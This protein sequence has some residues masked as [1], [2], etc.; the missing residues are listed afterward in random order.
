MPSFGTDL[1]IYNNDGTATLG[2]ILLVDKTDKGSIAYVNDSGISPT[3]NGSAGYIYTGPG[4]W[5]GISTT[6]NMATAEYGPGTQVFFKGSSNVYAVIGTSKNTV[7]IDITTLSG[8]NTLTPNAA[9]NIQVK[10]KAA[11]YEDSD[12]SNTIRYV[13]SRPVTYPVK[14]DLIS[15]GGDIYRVL[16][17]NGSIAEVVAMDD[18]TVTQKF[19]DSG[20]SNVYANSSLDS[21]LTS[22]FYNSLST[23]IQNAIVEKTLQQDSWYSGSNPSAIAK[24]NGTNSDASDYTVSLMSTTF[25]TS[26]SRK[27]YVLSCQDVIDYLEVTPAMVSSNTT[28]TAENV[29]KMFWNETTAPANSGTW[30]RS[31]DSE[32]SVIV[33][34]IDSNSGILYNDFV[35]ESHTVRPAFQ[36]DLSKVEWLR[37]IDDGVYQWIDNPNLETAPESDFKIYWSGSTL[38]ANNVYGNNIYYTNLATVPSG[39]AGIGAVSMLNTNDG[40]I[41]YDGTTWKY[42]GDDLFTATDTSKLRTIKIAVRQ[43]QRTP[44]TIPPKFYDWAITEGNFVK[45]N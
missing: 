4:K 42:L 6:P 9:Y 30:L 10:A 20:N 24:Y 31:A 7:S 11:G 32:E 36:I 1:T 16:K 43:Q 41:Q 38:T 33:F 5:L 15:L 34:S 2:S 35:D 23:A 44:A 8:Y 18:S 12:L 27:C 40:E 19:D 3:S 21:Y 14:G 13:A 29:W 45:Q 39:N 22:T 17:I 28:L 25:G 26:I 37:T